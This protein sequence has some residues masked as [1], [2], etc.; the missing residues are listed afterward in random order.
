L[1]SGVGFFNV[2]TF[3]GVFLG[4]PFARSDRFK[5][6]NGYEDWKQYKIDEKEEATNNG[7][8]EEDYNNIDII[9]WQKI[10]STKGKQSISR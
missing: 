3:R 1:L 9:D 8:T 10:L 2:L 7:H 4:S 6:F 5:W